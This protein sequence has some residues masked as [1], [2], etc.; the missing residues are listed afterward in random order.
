M[1]TPKQ[2]RLKR[3]LYKVVREIETH[4]DSYTIYKKQ[5]NDYG[6]DVSVPEKLGTLQGLFHVEKGHM[7]RNVS[8]GTNT[9]TKGNP[10]LLCKY[11]DVKKLFVISGCYTKIND[12]KYY[13]SDINNV[14]EFCILC[15]IAMER[16]VESD[17]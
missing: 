3:E 17:D 12:K 5:T 13:F 2:E 8:D 7:T 10:Y 16:E 6:E 4:G 1:N 11:G 15:N 14:E 9:R